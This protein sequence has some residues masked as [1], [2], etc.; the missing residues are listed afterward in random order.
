MINIRRRP[1]VAQPEPHLSPEKLKSHV[2]NDTSASCL[3]K[4][5]FKQTLWR[6]AAQKALWGLAMIAFLLRFVMI[7]HPAEVVFDEVHFGGFASNYLRREYYFD[8][9]PP[10]GKLM[11]AGVGWLLGYDGG[12]T[13]GKIGLSYAGTTAPYIG[14][15]MFMVMLG[16]FSVVLGYAT[17]IEMGFGVIPAALTGILMVFDN[18]LTIQSRLILLDS[19]LIFF[20]FA[21]LYSWI[22]F[23]QQRRAPF[24]RYWWGWLILTGAAIGAATSVKMVGLFT[25]G[26][27]G[28]A[29][30]IDLWELADHRR[31]Y[32]DRLLLKHFA[33]R[34]LG[35]ILVPIVIYLVSYWIHFAVLTRT[36]PGDA[37]MSPKFQT[38]LEGNQMNAKSRQVYLGHTIRLKSRLEET[39]LHSH[40]HNYPKQHEDGKV[41][42]EGQQVTGYPAAD[43]NNLWRILPVEGAIISHEKKVPVRN[44]DHIRLLH[45]GTGKVLYT[46]DVASPLTRTNMEITV[47]DPE[48]DEKRESSIW[49]IDIKHGGDS[50]KA[51]SSQIR[52]VHKVHDVALTNWQQPLPKWGFNQRE[53]N[54]DKRG[55]EE[56]SRWIV[57]EIDEPM[58]SE[59][60]KALASKPKVQISFIQKFIE[61]QLAQLKHNAALIDNHPF[62]SDPSS[63]P[64]VLRGVSYWDQKN[65][66]RIYF[67]GNPVAWYASIAGVLTFCG[68]ALCELYYTRRGRTSF[69]ESRTKSFLYKGA[70]IL[71][72]WAVHYLPFFTMA[73]TLYLHHYLPAYMM[74]AMLTGALLDYIYHRSNYPQRTMFGF[75]ILAALVVC[76]FFYF[77]PIT[78]GTQTPSADLEAKKWLASWDWA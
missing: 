36:G 47:V 3:T 78:Y 1:I 55:H 63:W 68:V 72:A 67:I 57:W 17:L 15:R 28:V 22:K 50:L 58:D 14:L 69:D 64:L 33:A 20:I 23:R 6:P 38:S 24:K 40:A 56:N 61:L 66:A 70:F 7:N 2:N 5:T 12:F 77:A 43:G 27:V 54:G 25:V 21:S 60:E 32:S 73:R 45:I 62:R 59:E 42:S 65:V 75:A 30:L 35:L 31:K 29:T 52:L 51:H 49:K 11:I 4:G 39:F 53:I 9:H 8:V 48:D 16:V 41:S 46:H 10:L 76:T 74:S 26:L 13:F 37:F 34:I 19:P 18:A 44:G 71:M